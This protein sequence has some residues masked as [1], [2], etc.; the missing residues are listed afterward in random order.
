MLHSLQ[1]SVISNNTD[2]SEVNYLVKYGYGPR[3]Y[4]IPERLQFYGMSP[5]RLVHTKISEENPAG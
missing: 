5:C 4:N 2:D 1:L 3:H